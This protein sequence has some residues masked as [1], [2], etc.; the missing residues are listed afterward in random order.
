MRRLAP[1]LALA[2]A[3]VGAALWARAPRPTLAGDAAEKPHLVYRKTYAEALLEGRIRGVPVLVTRRRDDCGRC[4]RQ[5]RSVLT[6]E[7]F[8]RWANEHLVV[9][10]AHNDLGHDPVEVEGEDGEKEERCPLYPGL[11]CRDHLDAAVD[12]DNARGEGLVKI[13]FIELCPNTWLV[14]PDGQVL[15]IHDQDQFQALEIRKQVEALQ[16]KLGT[17]LAVGPCKMI[18]KRLVEG[19]QAKEEE[20]W[21]RALE[22]YAAI[23]KTAPEPPASLRAVVEDRL[24]ALDEE[25]EIAADDVFEAEEPGEKE[26][27]MA[28][29]LVRTLDITVY[30][31]RLPVRAALETWL[32]RHAPAPR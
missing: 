25:V 5:Y 16:E 19:D 20:A 12:I 24:E 28:G 3:G 22:S 11:V 30:G 8:V 32:A 6:N 2:L 23:E 31:K 29:E 1:V 4:A 27:R 10:V 14:S 17:A 7:V 13:P 18:R 26:R 15:R 9:I 21:R